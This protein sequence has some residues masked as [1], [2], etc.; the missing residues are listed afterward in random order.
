M[1]MKET[2]NLGKTKFSMRGNLPKKE[3]QRQA[4]WEEN[5][6]YE[7][8]LA[9]NKDNQPF[10]LHDGPP[11]ANGN[12]HI[13]HAMNKISKDIIIRSKAMEGYYAPYVPG[14]DTHGLPIEQAVTNSGVD[15]K[16]L[17]TATFRKICQ[18]Y[19]TKQV[20][21]QRKDF[22]RLGVSGE[23]ENPYVT[24]R[25]DFEAQEVRVFGK[26][27]EN[28]LIYQ[29]NK[30]VY[31]S[32]S[33]ESTLAEAEIEYKDV[34]TPSIYVAYK[35]KE[36]FGKL[37]SD[38]EFVIWTT[39]PWTLPAS[40]GISV[41]PRITYVL[42]EIGTHHYLVAKDLLQ[43]LVG[44]FEW[45]DYQIVQEIQGKELDRMVAQHPFYDRDILVMNGEHVTTDTGTGLVHTAPGHGEDDYQ[46]GKAYGLE[47]LSPLN[48]QGCFTEEAPGFEGMFY[49][50]GNKLAISIVKEKGALL[51]LEYF[52]H[53]YP[54]DW[55]TKKP[56]IF[57]ALPQWFCSVD[58]IREKTLSIINHEVKW[59]H[60]SGQKRIYNMIRDRGDWVISRQRVWGV[61]LPIFY[62][63]DGTPII[64]PETTE[65]VAQLFEKYGSNVWFER[66]AKDL[67]PEGFTS[68]HSP[69]GQFTKEKD[70]MDVWFDSGSSW[71]GVLENEE[72]L[73][74]PADMYL[75][76]S[77]QYRGWFNSSLLTSVA[78]N[79]QAPYKQVISQGFV[80]DGE[81][82][83]MSKSLGN[84][85][86]PNDVC[87]QRGADILR[88]WV[89][90]VD[91]RYD[92]RISDDILAQV[93][94]SYRKIR[95]TLRFM[96]GNLS[97]FDV[98]A[99][100]VSY[101][102]LDPIDQFILVELDHL[103]E[104]V[105]EAYDQFEFNTIIQQILNFLTQMMSSFY[106]DY[107]KDVTYIELA[108]D[109]KRR[110]MQTVMYQVTK[111]LTILLTPIIPHTTEEIWEFLQEEEDYAQLAN[112]P[113]VEHYENAEELSTFWHKFLQFRD[114][115]NRTLETARNE[116]VIG[117]SLEARLHIYADA[118][119]QS[120]LE[121]VGENLRIYLM[122][123]QLEILDQAQ[124]PS[125]ADD[126]EGFKLVVTPAEGQVCERCRGV[127]P[128]VGS[129]EQAP[130]LCQRCAQ[131]V[132]DHFPEVLQAEED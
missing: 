38:T 108:D 77:D 45:E 1:K 116:K 76:G 44:K 119:C 68:E 93:S 107:S 36:T 21:Q 58:K 121:A 122:V 59:W 67:L 20:D 33:S 66:E 131:I 65:Y 22:K 63:E 41:H 86:S 105:R 132:I 9:K 48:D 106:L 2:L 69:N 47:I 83:K 88:L 90:S 19:A 14:W 28:G 117:K 126:Y 61:P 51:K 109:P 40:M 32:P 81:G 11:Y 17:S 91:S 70:I 115:T 39:T 125:S 6:V 46:I 127:Y 13:G 25:K 30:P 118:D 75:E 55:R 71:A 112:F 18:E 95:N 78:V 92:V 79:G 104:E 102:D 96:L 123:S 114:A 64:T 113:E 31:W 82:R 87:D 34:E 53:S 89:T 72:H 10:V 43:S 101:Q 60:P 110:N 42:V 7:Q 100:S 98:K 5:H 57:R 54:H 50:E 3:P 120:F 130:T 12:I 8:R 94:E 24:Y 97:D 99:N 56:V 73:V 62:A 35:A 37:P 85:V 80:N 52:T 128:S 129:C 111:K 124:A 74:Y 23:W 4:E 27:A 15:R 26:M 49:E 103:V 29:G 84:T 16:A